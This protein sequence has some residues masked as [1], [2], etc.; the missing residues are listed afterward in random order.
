MGSSA[1]DS[2]QRLDSLVLAWSFNASA[3]N[4]SACVLPRSSRIRFAPMGEVEPA[5][6]AGRGGSPTT[7]RCSR[8][9][10]Y[11]ESLARRSR[12][13]TIRDETIRETET[14]G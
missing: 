1:E 2:L 7:V 10:E 9:G 12:L 11:I 4:V 3:L 13:A 6:T 8:G 5:S 14:Q